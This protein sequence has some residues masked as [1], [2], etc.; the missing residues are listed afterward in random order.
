M[1]DMYE[2]IVQ[3]I[4]SSEEEPI[5]EKIHS[6]LTIKLTMDPKIVCK[7]NSHI[8]EPNFLTLT[9]L[10]IKTS[11]DESYQKLNS[12]KGVTV[13][14]EERYMSAKLKH[15]WRSLSSPQPPQPLNPAL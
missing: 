5:W 15:K 14:L 1:T 4:L 7:V 11:I 12:Y 8:E 2:N 10:K 13:P 9:K 6:V 3:K